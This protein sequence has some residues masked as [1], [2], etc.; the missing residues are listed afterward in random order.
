MP[1]DFKLDLSGETPDIEFELED[2]TKSNIFFSLNTM[3]NSAFWKFEFGSRVFEIKKITEQNLRLVEQRAK[4]AL[5][6]MVDIGKV[7]KFDITATGDK[8]L[9]SITLYI[10]AYRKNADQVQT[11]YHYTIV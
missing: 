3:R 9:G 5:R 2:S 11:V 8:T 4:E 10:V 6:W 1:M 7:S